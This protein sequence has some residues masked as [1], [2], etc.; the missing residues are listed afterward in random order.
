V[1][2]LIR[3]P[4][5]WV[6]HDHLDGFEWT[7]ELL[8]EFAARA[9]ALAER[10]G[11]R[12]LQLPSWPPGCCQ[13]CRAATHR[14]FRR[15]RRLLCREC[16]SSRLRVARELGERCNGPPVAREVAIPASVFASAEEEEAWRAK[17]E[18]RS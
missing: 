17:R 18:D 3:F 7:P 2:D 1:G 5:A 6:D 13:D 16:A 12:R 9:R 11:S 4:G 10:Y 14:R 8:A 15:G